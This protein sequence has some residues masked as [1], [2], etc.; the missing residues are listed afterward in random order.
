[1]S[2]KNVFSNAVNKWPNNC[3]ERVKQTEVTKTP[4]RQIEIERKKQRKKGERCC[5]PE[6]IFWDQEWNFKKLLFKFLHKNHC[7]TLFQI[8][9][10][11]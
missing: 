5:E 9:F 3:S 8:I 1:M 2:V 4:K 7:N 10:F 6:C 11:M